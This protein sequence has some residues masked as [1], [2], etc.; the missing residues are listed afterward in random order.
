M[1]G[2]GIRGGLRKSWTAWRGGTVVPSGGWAMNAP[3]EDAAISRDSVPLA[4]RGFRVLE[5]V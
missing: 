1:G 2:R 4:A 5:R 3:G